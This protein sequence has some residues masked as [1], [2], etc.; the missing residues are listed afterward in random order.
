MADQSPKNLKSRL[1][2]A[3]DRYRE[4]TM[5]QPG[6]ELSKNLGVG[7]HWAAERKMLRI[8]P[9]RFQEAGAITEK[10][11]FLTIIRWKAPRQIRNAEK[12]TENEIEE[13][14]EA[15]YGANSPSRQL[16]TLQRLQGVGPSV[17]TA[18][19]MFYDP[20]EHTV[21]DPR[22]TKAL[23]ELGYWN[24]P[25]GGDTDTYGEYQKTCRELAE[26]VRFSLRELDRALFVLGGS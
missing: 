26:E 3:R 13:I 25:I 23:A 20:D 24:G 9:E 17:A 1:E 22:A 2:T 14:T 19:L 16:Q 12:N 4:T 7:N 10:E 18:V 15:A 21:M 6:G 8:F 11:D 5:G